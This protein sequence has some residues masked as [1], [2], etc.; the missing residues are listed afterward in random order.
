MVSALLW[1]VPFAVLPTI[2]AVVAD[3]RWRP[4]VLV[5]VSSRG[6]VTAAALGVAS[7]AVFGYLAGKALALGERGIDHP[8]FR[9]AA[10]HQVV[11]WTEANKVLTQMGGRSE[12][13]A[14]AVLAAVVLAVLI[15]PVWLAPAALAFAY[16]LERIGQEVLARLVDRGHPPTTLGTYPSGG[17]ARIVAVYGTVVLLLVASGLIR[18]R[19][20]TAAWAVVALAA[21]VEGYTR[22]YLLKHWATDAVGGWLFGGLVLAAVAGIV[23]AVRA[24]PGAD[25]PGTDKSGAVTPRWPGRVTAPKEPALA[26]ARSARS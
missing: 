13:K 10:G 25:K 15:R 24:K 7:V 2:L 8:V 17:C 14:L 18:G 11:W 6:V 3:R 16:G 9:W 12:A 19:W 26:T 20:R 21:G 4:G 1:F 23:L 5:A 22:I